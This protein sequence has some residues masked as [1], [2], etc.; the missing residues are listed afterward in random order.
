[1]TGIKKLNYIFL[2]LL[3]ITILAS[4]YKDRLPPPKEA[5]PIILKEP[6]QTPTEKEPFEITIKGQ[7]YY[8]KPRFNY[9][10]SGLVVSHHHS[11]SITDYYHEQWKDYVNNADVCVVYDA[12]VKN[13][14]YQRLKF[15]SGSWT[16]Y[17]RYNNAEDGSMFSGRD[18]SNNHLLTDDPVIA[19][20]ILST[21]KGDQI[22]LKGYLVGYGQD[23]R[24]LRESSTTRDDTGCEVIFVTEYQILKPANQLWRFIF[25]TTRALTI[26]VGLIGIIIWF[27]K[28]PSW[29]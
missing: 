9:E 5:L 2:A 3:S 25:K 14:V 23:E 16:C 21:K 20:R 15:S 13:G 17:Y 6:I 18:F 7:K 10:L 24:Y 12:N 19:K 29:Q 4:F 1:M 22:H 8:I 26:I 27:R 28:E 11:S